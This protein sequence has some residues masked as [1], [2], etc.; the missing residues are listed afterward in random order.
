M[1]KTWQ[2]KLEDKPSFPKVLGLEEG[3]PYFGLWVI[4]SPGAAGCGEWRTTCNGYSNLDISLMAGI[5]G[6]QTMYWRNDP[7]G[8]RTPDLHRDRVAC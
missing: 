4:S 6:C 2:E 8:I 3:F 7:E 1:R 5:E